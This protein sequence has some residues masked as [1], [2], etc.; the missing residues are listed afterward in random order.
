MNNYKSIDEL[1]TNLSLLDQGEWIYVNLNSWSSNPGNT[2][3]YYIS[4]DYIQDL[5]DD[6]IYLDEED[7]EMPLIVKELNLRGWM[8]VSSLNYIAKN[9]SNGGYDNKWF[10]DEINYYREYDTFR[11]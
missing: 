7:M 6:E 9:K 10:I 5:S 4:W 1:I 2:D 8:L 3:F 11:T